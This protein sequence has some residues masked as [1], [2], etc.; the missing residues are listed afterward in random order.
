MRW[1]TL[2]NVALSGLLASGCA[3]DRVVKPAQTIHTSAVLFQTQLTSFQATLK[4]LQSA[5]QD[6]IAANNQQHDQSQRATRRLQITE[7]ISEA[8][9]PADVFKI[10]QAQANADVAAMTAPPAAAPSAAPMSLPIDQV[11]SAAKA[12]GELAKAPGTKA[13]IE[14][15]RNFA[16]SVNKDFST[17]KPATPAAAKKP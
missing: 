9:S 8:G 5:K 13:D 3:S 16:N 15:L 2:L 6:W 14:F 11:G 7:D 17:P 10:L 4:A 1:G 12:V